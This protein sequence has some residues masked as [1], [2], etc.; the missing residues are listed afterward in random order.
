MD[1]DQPAQYSLIVCTRS[2]SVTLDQPIL[3]VDF[4]IVIAILA[5]AL[6]LCWRHLRSG[7]E[8]L[9]QLS[10]MQGTAG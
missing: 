3:S 9:Y 10:R 6:F 2:V 8:P 1:T 7:A 5:L 4:R